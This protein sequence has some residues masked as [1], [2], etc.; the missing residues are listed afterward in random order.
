[1]PAFSLPVGREAIL[2]L[3]LALACVG[4]MTSVVFSRSRA[5]AVA[6]VL[7]AGLVFG[8][9]FPTIMAILLGHFAAAVHGRAVGIFFAIGGIGWTTIPILIGTY[10]RRAS[11]QRGFSIAVAAAAGLTL[12]ALVLVLR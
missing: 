5:L 4:L 12:V 3:V 10:A 11:I 8:P 7:G 9:I 1:L 6:T 2:V